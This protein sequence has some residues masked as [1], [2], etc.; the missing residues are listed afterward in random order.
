[1]DKKLWELFCHGFGVVFGLDK[2]TGNICVT[3]RGS[4]DGSLYKQNIIVTHEELSPE[5]INYIFA[6]ILSSF[7]NVKEDNEK[8]GIYEYCQKCVYVTRAN[9]CCPCNKCR[10]SYPRKLFDKP[11]YFEEDTNGQI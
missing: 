3:A 8:E 4:V 11:L 7:V 5:A 1:M 2:E 6:Q 10:D 9:W